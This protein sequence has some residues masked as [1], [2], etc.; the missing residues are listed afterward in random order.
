[1][2]KRAFIEKQVERS[3]RERRTSSFLRRLIMGVVDRSAFEH[4]GSSYPTRC[5]QCS[6]A[7]SLLL[8]DL[9][10]RNFL[11]LGAFCIAEVF[12]DGS[13]PR[14]GGFW[15]R[16]HHV[17]MNSEFGE[18]VDLTVSTLHKHP[19]SQKGA[20]LAAPPIW[21]SDC[22]RF[23]AIFRYL[24][25]SPANPDI[26]DRD[27]SADL[28][29]FLKLV[30]KRFAETLERSEVA[31]IARPQILDGFETLQRLLVSGDEWTKAVFAVQQFRVPFPDWIVGREAELMECWRTKRKAPSRLAQFGD[32]IA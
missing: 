32:I 5:I 23:P 10:I 13:P 16:D 4:Y 29:D 11:T 15:N 31:E 27:G 3:K 18:I 9:G 14:W 24:P 26:A 2:I 6:A 8:R 17:W 28:A 7:L 30:R 20:A 19:A 1:M 21:W 25:D 12:S 22:S